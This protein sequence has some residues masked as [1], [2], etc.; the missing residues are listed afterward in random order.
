[1]KNLI[2][3]V[4]KI[5][6]LECFNKNKNILGMMPHPERMIDSYLSGVDGSI[7]FE[8]LIGNLK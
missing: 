6:L 3:M 4:Q 1:M 5:I 8:N 2:L 7:F